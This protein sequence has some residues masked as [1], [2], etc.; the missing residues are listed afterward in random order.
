MAMHVT[1]KTFYDLANL[2]DTMSLTSLVHGT[3]IPGFTVEHPKL[4]PKPGDADF[5]VFAVQELDRRQRSRTLTA[6]AQLSGVVKRR[7][8]DP[9]I[10]VVRLAEDSEAFALLACTETIDECG[11]K[12]TEADDLDNLESTLEGFSDEDI[13]SLQLTK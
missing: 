9:F 6:R 5:T 10:E 2:R 1:A 4:P 11:E 7:R 3:V 8:A 13:A 12:P